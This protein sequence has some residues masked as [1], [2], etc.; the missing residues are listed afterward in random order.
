MKESKL[1]LACRKLVENYGGR[2]PKWV[3]PG[4]SGVQDRIV[5]LPGGYVAFVEFKRPG[6]KIEPLQVE[7]LT[8][9]RKHGFRAY[10]VDS[11]AQFW[12]DVIQ[13]WRKHMEYNAYT[14]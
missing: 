10:I 6:G 14:G 5:L 11:G 1:E 2:M 8:W 9:M 7:W 13:P 12:S 4:N 3:S